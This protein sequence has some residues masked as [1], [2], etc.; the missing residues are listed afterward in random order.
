M[1]FKS[2]VTSSTTLDFESI[3]KNVYFF[4]VIV[5]NLFVSIKKIFFCE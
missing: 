3:C 5:V 1:T 4:S 2:A